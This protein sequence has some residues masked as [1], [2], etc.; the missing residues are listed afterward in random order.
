MATKKI[1]VLSKYDNIGASSRYRMLQ[2]IPYLEECGLE[3]H[4]YELLDS[5]YLK[6]LYENKSKSKIEIMKYYIKRLKVLLQINKYDL[7]WIEKEVFPYLPAFIE[8]FFISKIPYVVDYDDAQ[9]HMYD[10]NK[11]YIVR[12]FLKNKI[13]RIMKNAQIVVVGNEYLAKRARDAGARNIEII[14]TVIDVKKYNIQC[15]IKYD[16]FTLGWIGSPTTSSYIKM[17]EQSLLN[18][19]KYIDFQLVMV[20]AAKSFKLD[21]I[22][23]KIVEWNEETEIDEISRFDVGIMPLPD[24]PWTR[25][26]CGFKLIQYMGCNLPVIASPIGINKRIVFDGVNGYLANSTEEWENKLMSL[27]NSKVFRKS[28]G[29]SGRRNVEQSY[30]LQVRA[31]E[32]YDILKT[33]IILK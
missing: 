20:G 14:P 1:L 18:L 6:V 7:V 22:D 11:R 28:A 12:A 31:P 21:G 24:E 33:A 16:K 23:L 4:I 13:D 3:L 30:S 26:K 5:E 15:P 8:L 19:S 9:F 17:I 27:Y 10:L 25:G 29:E 32:I 2:Y